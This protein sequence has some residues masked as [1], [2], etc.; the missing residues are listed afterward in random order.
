MDNE[1]IDIAKLVEAPKEEE[2]SIPGKEGK[3]RVRALSLGDMSEIYGSAKDDVFKQTFA[4]VMR[5]VVQPK[6]SW[7]DVTK[8][9]PTVVRVISEKINELSGFSKEMNE[10]AKKPLGLREAK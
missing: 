6:L 9:S 2:I 10:D 5:G 1:I 3:I 8:L 7:D 4:I